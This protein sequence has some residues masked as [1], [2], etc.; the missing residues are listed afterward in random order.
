MTPPG[1]PGKLFSNKTIEAIKKLVKG[2]AS[3]M[4]Q[5]FLC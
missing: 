1:K 5:L 2:N 3:F 4:K